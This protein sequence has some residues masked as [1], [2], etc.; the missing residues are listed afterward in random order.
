MSSESG[1]D[2][3]VFNEFDEFLP[4]PQSTDSNCIP[5]DS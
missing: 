4:K 2:D 3:Q 1:F 5:S